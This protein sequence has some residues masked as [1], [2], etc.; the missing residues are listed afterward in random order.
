MTGT[1]ADTMTDTS[2]TAATTPTRPRRGEY[3][4]RLRHLPTPLA[5]LAG[6]LI[7]GAGIALPLRGWVGVAGVAAGVALVAASYV[8]SS[9]AVAWADRINP[10]LVLPVGL[11]AYATKIV[12]LGLVMI[13]INAT[14]WAGIVPMGFAIVA[15]A[16]TWSAAQAA[17]TW[18]ARIPYVDPDATANR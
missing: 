12:L 15:A 13:G 10:R 7:V 4:R 17:W 5:A 11:T 9:L 1:L 18:R 14:N 8:A 2:S 3:G 6:V 16:L